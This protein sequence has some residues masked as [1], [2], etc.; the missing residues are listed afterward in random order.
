V[1]V[2]LRASGHAIGRPAREVLFTVVSR[3]QKYMS[4]R[5]IDTAIYRLGDAVASWGVL[6]AVGRGLVGVALVTMP[7]AREE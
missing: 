5:F 2:A 7:A 3:E 6:G 4:K 1:R